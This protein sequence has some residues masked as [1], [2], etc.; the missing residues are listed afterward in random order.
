M[1][2]E[3]HADS[4]ESCDES[5]NSEIFV[6]EGHPAPKEAVLSSQ[7]LQYLKQVAQEDSNSYFVTSPGPL[8]KVC[9][10]TT[11]P[12]NDLEKKKESN[13]EYD[14]QRDCSPISVP[15]SSTRESGSTH[16][17]GP[18]TARYR[19]GLWVQTSRNLERPWLRIEIPERVF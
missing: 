17:G 1:H 12:L 3:E 15:A 8:K 19:I 2:E 5:V 13:Q 11:S 9:L 4:P 14:C 7:V 16:D 10:Q 18:V 6:V